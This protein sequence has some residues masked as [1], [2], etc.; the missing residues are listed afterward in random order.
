MSITFYY[1]GY[2]FIKIRKFIMKSLLSVITDTFFCLFITF[3]LSLVFLTYF[4]PSNTAIIFSTLLSSLITLL[5]AKRL[6]DKRKKGAL[7]KSEQRKKDI[8]LSQLNF[9]PKHHVVKHFLFVLE[10]KGYSVYAKKGRIKNRP[11]I[12][13]S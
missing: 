2:N 12:L 4:F 7:K 5:V 3:L 13:L 8:A 1:L 11:L 9:L 6:T 10:K